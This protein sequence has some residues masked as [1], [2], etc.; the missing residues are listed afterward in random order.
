MNLGATGITSTGLLSGIGTL[1]GNVI[2]SGTVGPGNS[3]GTINITGNYTQSPT[4]T[5][6]IEVGGGTPGT[7]FDSINVTGAS[8]LSGQLNVVQFAGFTP[9]ASAVYTIINSTIGTTGNFTGVSVPLAYTGMSVQYLTQFTN[10]LFPVQLV[11]TP[12]TAAITAVALEAAASAETVAASGSGGGGRAA[13]GSPFS[14]NSASALMCLVADVEMLFYPRG[15]P[16][17]TPK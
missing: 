7:G 4:G 12:V 2:N 10:L 17:L 5:L 6:N 14:N 13:V 3:P 11:T 15:A 1:T 9:P 8:L 16:I